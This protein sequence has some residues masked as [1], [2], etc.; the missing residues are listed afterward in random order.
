MSLNGGV[1]VDYIQGKLLAM[2]NG[3]ES[4]WLKLNPTML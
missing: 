2:E 4:L 3:I 1:V